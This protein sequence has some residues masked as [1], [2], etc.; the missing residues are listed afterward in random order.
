MGNKRK[1]VEWLRWKPMGIEV[2]AG[3]EDCGSSLLFARPS[4]QIPSMHIHICAHTH[5]HT[6]LWLIR[7]Q[8]ERKT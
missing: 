2:E 3:A 7:G 1:A 8:K 4:I 6:P 5:M